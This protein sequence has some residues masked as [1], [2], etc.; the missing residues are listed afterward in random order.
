MVCRF[1]DTITEIFTSGEEQDSKVID[2]HIMV[3][4]PD[5]VGTK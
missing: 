3:R 5:P 2:G 4:V 1:F